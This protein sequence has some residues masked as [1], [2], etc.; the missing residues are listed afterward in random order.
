[1]VGNQINPVLARCEA[2]RRRQL[3]ISVEPNVTVRE[4]AGASI[5]AR[6]PEWRNRKHVRQ[7]GNTG[8]PL[9][10]C[11]YPVIGD[12]CVRDMDTAMI[13]RILQPIW[14]KRQ[15][16]HAGCAVASRRSSAGKP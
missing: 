13:V 2:Q 11:A 5:R 16:Q 9:G 6:E 4:A 15:R 12:V 10:T 8:N 3:D 1:M 7:R 14:T